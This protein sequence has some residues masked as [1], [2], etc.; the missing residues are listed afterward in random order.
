MRLREEPR[1]LGA[2]WS[3]EGRVKG[4]FRKARSEAGSPC[5]SSMAGSG[6]VLRE[7]LGQPGQGGI[8]PVGTKD[9]VELWERRSNSQ[10]KMVTVD[11][12]PSEARVSCPLC[13]TLPGPEER[14]WQD[15]KSQDCVT[16]GGS[17]E[18]RG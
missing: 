2:C 12:D 5:C 14:Y 11:S 18:D 13:K 16:S 9:P 7:D 17:G 10:G 8:C 4:A 3:G 6:S 15:L 1:G